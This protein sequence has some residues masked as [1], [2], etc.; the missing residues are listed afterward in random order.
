MFC[1]K[2]VKCVSSLIHNYPER[3]ARNL[4]CIVLRV[5]V[6]ITIS[7]LGIIVDDTTSLN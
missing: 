7:D 4:I 5:C 6:L 2:P 3:Y 1:R